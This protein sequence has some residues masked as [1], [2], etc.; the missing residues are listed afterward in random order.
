[1]WNELEDGI[2]ARACAHSEHHLPHQV[3]AEVPRHGDEECAHGH[4]GER[5]PQRWHSAKPV[6][7]WA[8]EGT[9]HAKA[10]AEER[11]QAAGSRGKHTVHLVPKGREPTRQR[12]H[13]TK[14]REVQASQSPSLPD[15]RRCGEPLKC[16]VCRKDLL[17][18]L[19]RLGPRLLLTKPS[20]TQLEVP[21]ILCDGSVHDKRSDD[22]RRPAE[23]GHGEPERLENVREHQCRE[24]RCR[25]YDATVQ[26]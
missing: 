7:D 4:H 16:I 19:L 25:A 5:Q 8:A 17:A 22:A 14:G 20:T 3:R 10:H 1:M 23:V 26:A 15:A 2:G 11:S 12:H 6:G 18:E 24:T 21:G 9:D 13:A